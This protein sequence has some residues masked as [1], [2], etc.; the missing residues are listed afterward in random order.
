MEIITQ[1]A[2]YGFL[3]IVLLPRKVPKWSTCK[4]IK[5]QKI[6]TPGSSYQFTHGGTKAKLKICCSG[7]D[8]NSFHF[9]SLN[10]ASVQGFIPF[11]KKGGG[12]ALKA[13]DIDHLNNLCIELNNLNLS[14]FERM[15]STGRQQTMS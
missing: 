12:L 2:P 7:R 11:I 4:G 15:F 1:V 9:V 13:I 14:M 5:R 3:N 10:L 8:L 6:I